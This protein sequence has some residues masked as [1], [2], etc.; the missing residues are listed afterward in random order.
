[1]SLLK[2][3][4]VKGLINYN[5]LIW[6]FNKYTQHLILLDGHKWTLQIPKK[7]FKFKTDFKFCFATDSSLSNG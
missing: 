3:N 6:T 1:M 2:K 7:D 4:M 5:P